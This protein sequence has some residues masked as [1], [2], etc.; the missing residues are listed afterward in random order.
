M[1]KN[2]I[3]WVD[4]NN[5]IDDSINLDANDDGEIDS[6]S[7]F[8]SGTDTGWNSLLWPHR[9]S[10]TS[11]YDY[12]R[13]RFKTDAPEIDGVY[14]YDYTFQLMGN[15][16][17]YTYGPKLGIIAHEMF[18][19]LSAPDLYHY[20]DYD[21]ISATGS[22][23]L[24]SSVG[25]IPN[26]M[27]GYMKYQYGN[28]IDE[29]N[30]I[31]ES[32]TY[33]LYPMSLSESNIYMINT[34]YSNEYVFLEYRSTKYGYDSNL[35]DSGLIAYRVDLDYYDDGNVYGYY[36]SNMDPR[37]EVFVFRPGITD[38]TE[39]I[40]FD[41]EDN[42]G[43]DED[44]YI[45]RAAIS[46]NNVYDEMGL[47]T[48]FLMFY[49]DGTLMDIRIYNVHEY[50]D[51]I[52]FDVYLP[53]RIELNSAVDLSM[54]GDYKLLNLPTMDYSATI[55]NIAND[56]I[57]YYTTDGTEPTT[58]SPVY[59]GQSIPISFTS[60]HIKLAVYVDGKLIST[61]SK[62]FE[63][64]NS[65]ESNH[66]PYGNNITNKWY[67]SFDQI[68]SYDLAFSALTEFEED[69]D[70][71]FITD[72]DV[73]T[74]YTGTELQGVTLSFMN[75]GLLIEFSSDEYLDDYFGFLVDIYVNTF[76]D[77]NLIGDYRITIN[78]GDE[79]LD[80]GY[81]I[82]TANVNDYYVITTNEVDNMTPGTYFVQYELYDLNDV[83]IQTLY[84]SVVVLDN[85]APVITLNGDEITYVELGEAYFDLGA[86]YSDNVDIGGDLESTDNLVNYNRIGTYYVYYNVTDSAG[87]VADTV[88]RTVIV[89]DTVAPTG[90]L[91]AS[92][93]TIAVGSD[94]IDAGIQ[95]YDLT[96]VNVEITGLIDTFTPGT[97]VLSYVLTDTSG[98]ETIIERY[99]TVYA[100]QPIVE[101]ILGP[102]VTTI[103]AGQAYHDGTCTV[104]VN[105][106]LEACT[107]IENNL[108]N[109]VAGEYTIVYG[110]TID[111]ITYRYSRYIFVLD[112]NSMTL[113][114]FVP[115]KKEEGEWL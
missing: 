34:G 61:I 68:T 54:A 45:D 11:Y 12:A 46:N 32:G 67:L 79:Y 115:A 15:T 43:I 73:T 13:S 38:L 30:E 103:I 1:L 10:L 108:D 104:Y 66:N 101:F 18:H 65:L 83:L 20:N 76:V 39:P 4:A 51:R 58:S 64:D 57:I 75:S 94:Y 89:R 31:T 29:V 69:Y 62:D 92:I 111:D 102:A 96:I 50:Q 90:I 100:I 85:V 82:I 109:E 49:S 53:P 112:D 48:N 25:D 6:L 70:Y 91:N 93:D 80:Q 16:Q 9:W 42:L 37:D 27:L 74:A 14:A 47:G 107:I 97:Y 113:P 77:F 78:Q 2:A 98:N 56:A 63:F 52:T 71:L 86:T 23:G 59:N 60:R 35:P 84:R 40:E 41:D 19:V 110:I 36:D 28:W 87:N 26:H 24:M 99:V 3:D 55:T 8:I 33:T 81:E 17:D 21:W 95:Y 106:I 88:V 105:G 72:G 114:L 5:L 7:F 22:W 44:G